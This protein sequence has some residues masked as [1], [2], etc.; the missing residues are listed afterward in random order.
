M[1]NIFYVIH[2]EITL[3]KPERLTS[4]C[5]SLHP[6]HGCIDHYNLICPTIRQ[7]V[8]LPCLAEVYHS[9][10]MLM[11]TLLYQ[12]MCFA[13]AWQGN[14]F[15]RQRRIHHGFGFYRWIIIKQ[16]FNEYAQRFDRPAMHI[17]EHPAIC[18]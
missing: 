2:S 10:R 8:L 12:H 16:L 18:R 11:K 6:I 1:S 13:P 4:I 15:C 9:T 3:T 7:Y 14:G 5:E 17:Y